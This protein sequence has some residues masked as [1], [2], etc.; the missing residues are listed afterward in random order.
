MRCGHVCSLWPQG[1]RAALR[2]GRLTK[3]AIYRCDPLH[4]QISKIQTA[5]GRAENTVKNRRE[6]LWRVLDQ[7]VSVVGRGS[8]GLAA[9]GVQ[10]MCLTYLANVLCVLLL[11]S[12]VGA[13]MECRPLRCHQAHGEHCSNCWSDWCALRCFVAYCFIYRQQRSVV[14]SGFGH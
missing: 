4:V 7:C 3:V 13:M 2:V 1:V 5:I 8:A 12:R 11:R 6:Q 9:D 10:V 14:S